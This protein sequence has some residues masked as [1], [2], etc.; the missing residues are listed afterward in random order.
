MAGTEKSSFDK[1][2]QVVELE[3]GQMRAVR[4]ADGSALW[5]S[6]FTPGWSWESDLASPG[7]GSCPM[8]HREYVIAGS[9]RYVMDDGSETVAGAGECLFIAPGHRAWVDGDEICV[10]L[11][12]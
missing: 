10:L 4:L 7:A 11:D 2:D 3:H 1:A 12:W 9:I 6:E 5:L 8:T